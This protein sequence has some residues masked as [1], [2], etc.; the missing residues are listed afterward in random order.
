LLALQRVIFVGRPNS[1]CLAANIRAS[2]STVDVP[3]PFHLFSCVIFPATAQLPL[4]VLVIVSLLILL[5]AGD[6]RQLYK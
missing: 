2:F 6:H 1:A 3:T 5:P 4:F